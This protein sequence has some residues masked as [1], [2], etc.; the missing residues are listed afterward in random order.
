MGM[1]CAYKKGEMED[2]SAEVVEA[3]KNMSKE[4]VLL[5]L[6]ELSTI[7]LR[8][9]LKKKAKFV[10][11]VRSVLVNVVTWIERRELIENFSRIS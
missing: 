6:Q 8:K 2:A 9:F 10:L 11:S 3:A 5:I 4:D 7:N 1:V